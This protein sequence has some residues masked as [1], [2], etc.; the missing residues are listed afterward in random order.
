MEFVDDYP[1]RANVTLNPV[2]HRFS[3]WTPGLVNLSLSLA[4]ADALVQGKDDKVVLFSAADRIVY[5]RLCV[6]VCVCVCAWG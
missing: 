2:Y 3:L 6:C 4:D 5:G 1:R